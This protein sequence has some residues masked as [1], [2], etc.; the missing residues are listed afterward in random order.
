MLKFSWTMILFIVVR[1]Y[2]FQSSAVN[3]RFVRVPTSIFLR[4]N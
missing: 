4:K 3:P 1:S 2:N